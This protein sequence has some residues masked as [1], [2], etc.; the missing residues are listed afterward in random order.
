MIIS[1]YYAGMI[2][3]YIKQR[4]SQILV[5]SYLYYELNDSIVSDLV[6]D[7]WSQDLVKL[8]YHEI[9]WYD[10]EFKDWDGSSGFH[11]PHDGFIRDK[12]DR[13]LKYKGLLL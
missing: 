11:L 12:A 3:T 4:R 2:A 9:D 1:D 8:C 6:F 7:K 5:H 13:L 10:K